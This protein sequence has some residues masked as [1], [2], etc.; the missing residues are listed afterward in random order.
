MASY[1]TGRVVQYFHEP[2]ASANI[3]NITLPYSTTSVIS[4][5]DTVCLQ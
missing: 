3:A 2:K 1:F 5:L 4:Y